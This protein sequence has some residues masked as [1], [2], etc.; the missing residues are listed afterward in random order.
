MPIVAPQL[1]EDL[2]GYPEGG[3]APVVAPPSV[4]SQP[5]I[6]APQQFATDEQIGQ[7]VGQLNAGQPVTALPRQEWSPAQTQSF[8]ARLDQFDQQ[9]KAARIASDQAA[10]DAQMLDQMSRVAKSA[11]DI[12]IARRNIDVMGLQ[13]DIQNGVPIHDAVSRHPMGLGTGF[14]GALRATAPAGTTS[15]VPPTGGAPGYVLDPRGV[16]HFPPGMEPQMA[17][18]KEEDLGGGV[19]G[20]RISP[21]HYQITHRPTEQKEGALTPVQTQRLREIDRQ[22]H[23]IRVN[24]PAR[25]TSQEYI[26]AQ[27]E[28]R[29]LTLKRNKILSEAEGAKPKAVVAPP[30]VAAPAG[31]TGTIHPM[32]TTKTGLVEGQIYDT[33]RGA[34]QWDGTHFKLVEKR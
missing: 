6:T 28:L 23:D 14:A 9:A 10:M 8:A 26:D 16:P 17:T 20:V 5:P 33:P 12:E 22:A 30:T 32:P 18:P 19:K 13:R 24:L 2:A 25:E 31:V 1:D 34:A 15:F 3:Q 21:Q 4:A 27:N 7:A 29:L 11:K